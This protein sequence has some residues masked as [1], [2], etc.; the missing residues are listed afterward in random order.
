MSSTYTVQEESERKPVLTRR[1]FVLAAL[2]GLITLPAIGRFLAV[3]VQFIGVPSRSFTGAVMP[4]EVPAG[5]ERDLTEVPKSITFGEDLVFLWKRKG[6][7]MAYSG[8]CPHA[9]CLVSYH[10]DKKLFECPCHGGV[11]D[12][13]ARVIAGP[14]PRDMFEHKVR[15]SMG[16]VLVGRRKDA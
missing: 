13:D 7:V 8:V 1:E 4:T 2:A 16:R 15:I 5:L 10:E 3:V 11:F 6:K 9:G 14:P 12:M